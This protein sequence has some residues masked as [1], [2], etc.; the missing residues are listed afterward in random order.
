[1]MYKITDA[2]QKYFY[3]DWP[4][5][6]T[7]E[8]WAVWHTKAKKRPVP[9][10]I[11]R[12]MPGWFRVKGM[13]LRD[14]E[15]WVRYRLQKEHHY[16]LIDTGLGYGY[17]EIET[18][19]LH[20]MFNMLK[21]FIEIEKAQK[22]YMCLEK[23]DVRPSERLAG[24]AHLDWEIALTH[25]KDYADHI[26]EPELAG[27][28]TEQALTAQKIKDLYL[29]WVDKHPTRIDPWDAEFERRKENREEVNMDFYEL[30]AKES[31]TEEK[32]AREKFWD[33]KQ[34]IEDAY[35]KE[36]DEMLQQLISIRRALWT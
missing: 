4:K 29:W 15:M 9:Y 18:R 7:M 14:I 28:P 21:D 26:G 22:H 6:A 10:W 34:A 1:M 27:Q 12:T 3:P 24:L 5:S 30:M 32:E 25:D 20:G 36:D 8:D 11:T 33:E 13:Q 31:D 35:M 17:H 2:I 23:G 16:H 19:M